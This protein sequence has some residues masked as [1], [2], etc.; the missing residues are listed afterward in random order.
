M[1]S[2]ADY[3]EAFV[4]IWL[5]G[6]TAPVVAG[7]LARVPN[8]VGQQFVFNYGR[9]YLARKNAIPIYEPEL[10]LQSGVL[11]LLNGLAMPNSIRDAAP[12]AWGRRVIINRKFGQRGAALDTGELNEIAYLLESG[13]DR[14]GALDFQRSPSTYT[15]R[16]T[17]TASLSDLLDAADSVERGVPLS[18]ETRRGAAAWF[19]DRRRAAESDDHREG[20]QVRRQVLFAERSL[21]RREGGVHRDAACRRSGPEHRAGRDA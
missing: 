7:R 8:E 10:P 16:E 15:P 12:D 6:E 21:Q 19:L 1:T 2:E 13:S 11:P 3:D 4:W 20:P 18:A 9:S 5:P 14:V 17:A